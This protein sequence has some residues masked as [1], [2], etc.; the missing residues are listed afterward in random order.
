MTTILIAEDDE[1]QAELIRRYLSRE[2]FAAEVVG[3][4]QDALTRARNRDVDL[5]VLDVML[6]TLDGFA[7]CRA[8]RSEGDEVPILMLTARGDEDDL[9]TG[10][11]LGA[12]DY[13]T[14]PYSPRELVARARALLRRSARMSA[15]PLTVGALRIDPARFETTIAGHPVDLTR[16]ELELLTVLAEHA[17]FVLSRSQLLRHL[18]GSEEYLTERTIDTHVKNLRAKIEADPRHPQLIRS[19]Y[20]V[21][22]KLVSTLQVSSQGE[23]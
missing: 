1:L 4:G 9:L 6:P 8:L 11:E 17:G 10:L 5:L 16:A 7:V 21:G 2:G 3:D 12:D 19:V 13:L 14:K 22:Y 23:A 20:G 18:H 15:E